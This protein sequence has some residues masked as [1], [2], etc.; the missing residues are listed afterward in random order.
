MDGGHSGNAGAV[1]SKLVFRDT[2][3]IVRIQEDSQ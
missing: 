1:T 2:L 3:S